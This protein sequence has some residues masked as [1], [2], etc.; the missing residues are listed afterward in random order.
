MVHLIR[1][2]VLSCAIMVARTA[3]PLYQLVKLLSSNS[4]RS[5]FS[6]SITTVGVGGGAGFGGLGASSMVKMTNDTRLN[7]P[8]TPRLTFTH[9][10]CSISVLYAFSCQKWWADRAGL[11]LQTGGH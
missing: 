7:T 9:L 1:K 5:S 11:V 2:Q 6:R 4:R 8:N 3:I 10:A